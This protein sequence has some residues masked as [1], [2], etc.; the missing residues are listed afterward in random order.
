M[1]ASLRNGINYALQ[2]ILNATAKQL[3]VT[4]TGADYQKLANQF[5][6]FF[7]DMLPPA[8][9]ELRCCFTARG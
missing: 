1:S 9:G 8:V 7:Q 3:V 6:P 4:T 5:L 2:T